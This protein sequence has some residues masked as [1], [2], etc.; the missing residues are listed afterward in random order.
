MNTLSIFARSNGSKNY[1]RREPRGDW[2]KQSGSLGI[3]G[4]P[5]RLNSGVRIYSSN[6]KQRTQLSQVILNVSGL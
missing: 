5:T 1:K 3:D 6:I 2:S 4:M